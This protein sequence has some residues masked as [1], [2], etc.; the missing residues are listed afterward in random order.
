MM[1]TK[2]KIEIFSAGCPL[3]TDTVNMVSN[4]ACSSCEITVLDMN[5]DSVATRAQSLGV[6]IVPS[7]VVNGQLASCC[8]GGGVD[9]SVLKDMGVGSP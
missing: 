2:R 8:Q 1:T 3:C 6:R 5:D 9:E 7:V 4:L